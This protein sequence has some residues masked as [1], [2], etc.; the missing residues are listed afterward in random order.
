[1]EA[2]RQEALFWADRAKSALKALPESD[3]RKMLTDLADYVVARVR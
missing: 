2:T 3:I 1:M